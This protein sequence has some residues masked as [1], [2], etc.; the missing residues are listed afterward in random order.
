MFFKMTSVKY[1]IQEKIQKCESGEK[2]CEYFKYKNGN[3]K[4][5]SRKITEFSTSAGILM[6]QIK[7]TMVLKE[8]K[9]ILY[10]QIEK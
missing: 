10:I 9:D 4:H 2:I 6:L 7:I 3:M 5:S 1:E 8:R